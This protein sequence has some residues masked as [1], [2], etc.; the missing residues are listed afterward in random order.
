MVLSAKSVHAPGYGVLSMFTSR[1]VGEQTAIY[2]SSCLCRFGVF[3]RRGERFPVCPGC[4][5]EVEWA[6]EQDLG[7]VG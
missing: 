2:R 1:S 4:A 7:I 3:R 6:L 5:Q